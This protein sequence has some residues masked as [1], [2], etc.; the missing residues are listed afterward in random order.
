M[1]TETY[2]QK[3]EG[4]KCSKKERKKLQD[5]VKELQEALAAEKRLKRAI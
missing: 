4:R 5:K 1:N 2:R 3:R